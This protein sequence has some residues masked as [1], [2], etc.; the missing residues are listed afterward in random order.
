MAIGLGTTHGLS[1]TLGIH[2][3]QSHSPLL[4]TLPCC[5]SLLQD[6]V[7]LSTWAPSQR[8]LTPAHLLETEGPFH[9]RGFIPKRP[10]NKRGPLPD[11]FLHMQNMTTVVASGCCGHYTR[12]CC[13]SFSRAPGRVMAQPCCPPPPPPHL[14]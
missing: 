5:S 7:G 3:Y 8:D 4:Q 6:M 9:V 11:F 10:L 2:A 1:S 13:E 12:Q 14:K